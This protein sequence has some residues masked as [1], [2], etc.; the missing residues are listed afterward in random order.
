[1]DEQLS[2]MI[3]PVCAFHGKRMSEHEGGRCLY[4]CICYRSLEPAE[5]VVDSDG[6]KW[7]VCKGACAQEAGIDEQ[8]SKGET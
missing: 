3:D 2:A 8:L 1:L 7:D 6:Q 4:C 5:C